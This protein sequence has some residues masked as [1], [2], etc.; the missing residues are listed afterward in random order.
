M[1]KNSDNQLKFGQV[2]NK[3]Y[4]YKKPQDHMQ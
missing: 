4:Y 2:R 3:M 1:L